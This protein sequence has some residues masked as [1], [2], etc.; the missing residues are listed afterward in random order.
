MER[1]SKSFWLPEKKRP[2]SL[3][4]WLVPLWAKIQS[5]VEVVCVHYS[6]VP[7]NS[8]K[9]HPQVWWQQIV[10]CCC[11]LLFLSLG[12]ALLLEHADE[13]TRKHVLSSCSCTHTCCCRWGAICVLLVV[14]PSLYFYIL[15]ISSNSICAFFLGRCNEW[16]YLRVRSPFVLCFC[17][18]I[19]RKWN[20]KAAAYSARH[21]FCVPWVHVFLQH[22]TQAFLHV[23]CGTFCQPF[24]FE[25]SYLNRAAY[26]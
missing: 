1:C 6:C 11:L 10:G 8:A 12:M 21:A 17:L 5:I 13:K 4:R 25:R 2:W 22:D 7:L 3:A 26:W 9:P 16:I 24:S 15:I 18:W 14:G 20:T 23:P 19:A